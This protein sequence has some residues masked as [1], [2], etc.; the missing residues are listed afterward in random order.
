[1]STETP[2]PATP[3]TPAETP[4]ASDPAGGEETK[5][6]E[7]VEFWK[8]QARDNEKRAKANADAATRLAEIEAEQMSE[9]DKAKQAAADA[10]AEAASARTEVAR[11]KLAAEFK[12][13]AEDAEAFLTGGDEDTMRAQAERLA[14]LTASQG[15]P[16]APR[17]DLSQGANGAPVEEHLPGA[18]RLAAA[19]GESK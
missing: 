14:A 19:Y 1:M 7:T 13:S 17:P 2:T 9:A 15:T 8:K 10:A 12:L 5:P 6:T 3:E 11:Y 18:P 16:A 4:P